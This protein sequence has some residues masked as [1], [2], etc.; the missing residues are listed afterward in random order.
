MVNVLQGSPE[1]DSE[2]LQPSTTLSYAR[3][4]A[5]VAILLAGCNGSETGVGPEDDSGNGSEEDPVNV[6]G[7]DD[8]N[9]CAPM[10]SANVTPTGFDTVDI[11]A[12]FD[13][14]N[15]N[16][17][18]VNGAMWFI[19]DETY[20]AAFTELFEEEITLSDGDVLEF[21]GGG[22]VVHHSINFGVEQPDSDVA[23]GWDAGVLLSEFPYIIGND[24][25]TTAVGL[26]QMDLLCALDAGENEPTCDIDIVAEEE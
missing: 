10:V 11:E 8:L 7:I 22:M 4:A 13:L 17:P 6:L 15:C 20:G 5:L 18:R 3:V 21:E 26:G 2:A 25:Y 14:T 1:G 16:D 19:S 9:D 12:V 23:L 24:E